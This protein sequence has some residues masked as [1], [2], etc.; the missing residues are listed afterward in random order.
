M[1]RKNMIAAFLATVMAVSAMTG[2]GKQENTT[3]SSE[4]KQESSVEATQE[5]EVPAEP[6]KLTI[7]SD[8][9]GSPMVSHPS[10][11]PYFQAIQ[12]A[13]NVEFEFI[14]SSG[15]ADTL[16][17]LIG[18]NTL[19]DL[20]LLINKSYVSG[21]LD[22]LVEAGAIVP[23]N[24][25]ME[26]GWMPN[27]RAY[28]DSDPEVDNLAKNDA[29]IYA[30]A[31]MIRAKD[32]VVDFTGYLV[33]KDWLDELK[34]EVPS[35]I[36]DMEEVLL[37]FKEE[38]G[39]SGLSFM[40]NATKWLPTSWGVVEGMYV[41]NG[42]I[43]YGYLEDAYK[44]YLETA[45]R[46]IDL[47]ILDPDT[48]T[49][50]NDT[51]WAKVATGKTPMLVGFTGSTISYMDTLK[52]EV[53]EMQFVPMVWPALKEGETFPVECSDLRVGNAGIFLSANCKEQEAAARVIDYMYSEEGTM[54]NNYGIEGVSYEMVDGKPVYTE[55][56]ENNPDG[57]SR[58]D[59]LSLYA[60]MEN[61]PYILTRDAQE[62]KYALQEQRDALV[63][64]DT[65]GADIK[66][67]VPGSMTDEEREEYNQ[68]MGDI[69]TYVK[70][71]KL[72]FILGMESLDNYEAFRE[73]LIKMKIE[74]A[75]EIQ[76]AAY[77]R[78]INR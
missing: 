60:G 4:V 66:M 53:P 43:K 48:F 73:N 34:L 21:G 58:A 77:D 11:T 38:K 5:P 29:G 57:L 71:Y 54:L 30:W 42:T 78:F 25:L 76:Q 19:P 18:S 24:D 9:T 50:D 70:E 10:E 12:E 51:L 26:K 52:A 45:N 17:L 32:S 74:R 75:I 22:S 23:M 65:K 39:A 35:T 55:L 3:N 20:V 59:A 14:D 13:C 69:D 49:Q 31:P 41:D 62:P 36:E 1:K 7:W 40:G 61:K 67:K 68:I 28:L 16:S 72:K 64:W 2:C 15:G 33:R 27:L 37:A 44:E 8:F 46:W 6:A 56:I 47:G 63:A